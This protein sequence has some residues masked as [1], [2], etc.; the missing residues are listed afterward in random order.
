MWSIVC[1]I[2]LFICS[3]PSWGADFP[4]HVREVLH[5]GHRW[6]HGERA[7]PGGARRTHCGQR[8]GQPGIWCEWQ[9]ADWSCGAVSRGKTFSVHGLM[10]VL[11]NIYPSFLHNKLIVTSQPQTAILIDWESGNC[12]FGRCFELSLHSSEV[13][14]AHLSR[15]QRSLSMTGFSV[16]SDNN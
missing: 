13:V 10:R 12:S 16:A 7:G 1:P 6:G 15:L 4:T 2:Y 9:E 14:K 8:G 11:W 5:Y 3:C